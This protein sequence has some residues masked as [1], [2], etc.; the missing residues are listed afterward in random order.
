MLIKPAV[1]QAKAKYHIFKNQN[2]E[3][4]LKSERTVIVQKDEQCSAD[5]RV[6]LFTEKWPRKIVPLDDGKKRKA[7]E[8]IKDELERN[9]RL[10][11][12]CAEQ[13]FSSVFQAF[14]E[15]ADCPEEIVR[16]ASGFGGGGASTSY[17][18]CGA[19]SG[20]LMG[21]GLFWGRV[22][23]MDFF[24]TVG[25]NSIEEAFNDPVRTIEYARI[26]NVYI[27]E[28]KNHF[29]SVICGKLLRNYFDS[30]G[31]LID[32]P[33]LKEKRNELCKGFITWGGLRIVQLIRSSLPANRITY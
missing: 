22:N 2:T 1:F 27:K 8:I 23:P 16:I 19:V 5:R 25:L 6:I 10:G 12:N 13:T 26:F 24:Q 17:G 18:L 29:G 7:F 11:M 9:S 31:I 20:G 3:E 14:K 21:L 15:W 30:H 32:D 4:T 33:E 28:F